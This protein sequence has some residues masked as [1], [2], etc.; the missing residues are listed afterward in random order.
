[1]CLGQPDEDSHSLRQHHGAHKALEQL[2]ISVHNE[3]DHGRS[4][5]F[6]GG[7]WSR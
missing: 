1:M 7:K 4:V 2:F 3:A 6:F 5:R